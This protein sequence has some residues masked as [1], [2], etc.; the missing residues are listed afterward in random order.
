[1]I[2]ASHQHWIFLCGCPQS[3]HLDNEKTFESQDSI[4][5]TAQEHIQVSKAGSYAQAQSEQAERA[6]H[7]LNE[8]FKT[9]MDPLNTERQGWPSVIGEFAM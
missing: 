2:K 9:L 1:M 8:Q 3:I 4:I 5:I 6:N 7:Y